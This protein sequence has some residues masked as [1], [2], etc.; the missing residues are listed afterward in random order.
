MNK[1]LDHLKAQLNAVTELRAWIAGEIAEL[2]APKIKK[3][4]PKAG[5]WWVGTNGS[6]R[7]NFTVD[8]ARDH[9][10]ERATREQAEAASKRMRTFNRLDAWI[11]EN[12]AGDVSCKVEFD[13]NS[14][15]VVRYM[16]SADVRAL[17]KL[18]NDGV[19]VL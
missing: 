18:V 6:T 17:E 11:G 2:E 10:I 15:A 12:V 9:G 16:P 8:S 14:N 3:W 1:E 13:G 7:K 5:D 19:V 4:E